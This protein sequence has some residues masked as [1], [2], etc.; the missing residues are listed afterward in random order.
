M[1]VKKFV[2]VQTFI[3][4]KALQILNKD[5]TFINKYMNFLAF[6]KRWKQLPRSVLQKSWCISVVEILQLYENS[7]FS[8]IVFVIF[9][10][11]HRTT[12][13]KNSI[14]QYN[15]LLECLLM[16]AYEMLSFFLWE[17]FFRALLQVC[18]CTSV[19]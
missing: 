12:T 2:L 1:P 3:K 15:F 17:I 4:F 18:F 9:G 19:Q 5:C 16:A 8:Q 7:S 6:S 10:C 13:M 14:L 11:K